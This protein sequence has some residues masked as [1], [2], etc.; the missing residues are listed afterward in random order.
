VT[1]IPT[2]AA[3][4]SL[5]VPPIL[6]DR[7]NR[8]TFEEGTPEKKFTF[9][10]DWTLGDW[11]ATAKATYYG[12]VLIPNNNAALDYHSGNHTL[13]DLEARYELPAGFN[14]AIGINNVFDEYPNATPAL[15]NTNGPIGFPSYSPF[16][17][18]G[19]FLY[20]RLG[21]KW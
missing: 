18:N 19:R 4:S 10:A 6:F 7:G 15:V 13:V 11:G 2:T 9:A 12:D 1:R 17:F 5:P 20:A 14:A 8:L 16:G 3:L 21:A